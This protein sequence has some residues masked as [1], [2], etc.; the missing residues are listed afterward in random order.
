MSLTTRVLLALVAGLI[1]GIVATSFKDAGG[2]AL[3]RI[4]DP[5]GSVWVNALQMTLIPL[6]ASMLISVIASVPDARST[7]RLGMRAFVVFTAFLC[8]TAV[9][10][11][12]IGPALVAM[13]PIDAAMTAA[14]QT[15][16]AGAILTT[17]A[18]MPTFAQTLIDI[19]PANPFR[20][21]ADGAMLPLVVFSLA[22]GAAAT[23]IPAA[24]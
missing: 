21:A 11:I 23:R 9:V 13:L 2:G 18:R 20:A 4:A 22:L 10:S 17:A 15:S 19:V 24:L 5:V 3:I 7:G 14:L 8:V 12:L 1:T 6:V 16:N